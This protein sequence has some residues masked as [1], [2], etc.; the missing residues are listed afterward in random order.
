MAQKRSIWRWLLLGVLLVLL[1]AVGSLIYLFESDG[2]SAGEDMRRRAIAAAM[3]NQAEDHFNKY[4]VYPPLEKLNPPHKELLA[5]YLRSGVIIYQRDP[6]GKDY[7]I[8]KCIFSGPFK[9][10]DGKYSVSWNG[11]QYSNKKENITRNNGFW[12]TNSDG[13]YIWDLH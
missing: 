10:K 8:I 11:M 7:F 4:K 5:G 12:D 13:F 3:K 2:G 6:A 1:L 9:T